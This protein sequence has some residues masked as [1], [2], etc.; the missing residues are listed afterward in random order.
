M[1]LEDLEGSF[2]NLGLE[3]PAINQ[4]IDSLVAYPTSEEIKSFIPTLGVC[5]CG[6]RLRMENRYEAFKT[7]HVEIGLVA[8]QPVIFNSRTITGRENAQEFYVD[9][10]NH[11]D[12]LN[13]FMSHQRN[14]FATGGEFIFLDIISIM[15]LHY[16]KPAFVNAIKTYGVA[17]CLQRLKAAMMEII[18]GFGQSNDNYKVVRYYYA[19]A[20]INCQVM[21]IPYQLKD[22]RLYQVIIDNFNPVNEMID[23]KSAVLSVE[24]QSMIPRMIEKISTM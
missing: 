14:P 17:L 15:R 8:P 5:G 4:Y 6:Y 1:D 21:E 10:P 24:I 23:L 12:P 20:Y 22:T 16:Q 18:K 9:F 3:D 11:F 7:E 2:R 13:N 19:A